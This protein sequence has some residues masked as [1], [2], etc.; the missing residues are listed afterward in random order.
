MPSSL[1]STR[2]TGMPPRPPMVIARAWNGCANSNCTHAGP[3]PCGA[4]MVTAEFKS[5]SSSAAASMAPAFVV[6]F[7]LK[8]SHV[9]FRRRGAIGHN[10]AVA[11]IG[12]V[13][14][15]AAAASTAPGCGSARCLKA[16]AAACR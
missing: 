4:G 9:G 10:R 7:G 2:P 14:L 1:A 11:V 15:R 13:R 5:S 6:A 16:A 12:G 3:P 8:V